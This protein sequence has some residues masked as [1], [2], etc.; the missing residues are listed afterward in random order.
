MSL[1]QFIRDNTN[2]GTDIASV[3][4]DVMN[5]HIDGCMISHRLTAARLLIIYGHD[6]APDFIANNATLDEEC[7]DKWW[8]TIDPEIQ[9]FV[10]SKTDDGRDMCRLL[11]E[12]LHGHGKKVTPGHRVSAAK[13]LLGRAFGKTPTRPLPKPPH[14]TTPTVIPAEA[15][16]QATSSNGVHLTPNSSP[17]TPHSTTP[18]VIPTEAGTQTTSSNGV[19]LTPNSSPL[20]P[21]DDTSA[22]AAKTAILAEPEQELSPEEEA[23]RQL[24]FD[25]DND[26]RYTI[27]DSEI[28][29]LMCECDAPDFDPYLAALDEDYFKSYTGC[30]DP[31]CEVHGDPP[32]IDFDPNDFHY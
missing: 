17:L 5:D 20:T 32:K 27:L 9:K 2:D 12:V 21:Q 15:G 4:I 10:M 3:L 14:A 31:E 11:I 18:T 13:E 22:P 7:A 8:K 1:A 26:P 29:D 6:D 19:H 30:K 28:Y 24:L 23:R 16:T 25:L